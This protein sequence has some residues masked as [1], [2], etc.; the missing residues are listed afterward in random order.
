MSD[1]KLVEKIDT[2]F[3]SFEDRMEAIQEAQAANEHLNPDNDDYDGVE[4][5]GLSLGS[6]EE[7]SDHITEVFQD[8]YDDSVSV[9]EWG[10]GEEA[11]Q[12]ILEESR[13]MEDQETAYR[14]RLIQ[15]EGATYHLIQEKQGGKT[16]VAMKTSGVPTFDVNNQEDFEDLWAR[17]QGQDSEISNPNSLSQ[18]SDYA[19]GS[20]YFKE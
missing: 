15:E 17:L 11:Q 19:A 14:S 9:Y 2:P 7:E 4:V 20:D 5:E 13:G 8:A 3:G 1:D 6:E 12:F 10:E 18:D 16:D